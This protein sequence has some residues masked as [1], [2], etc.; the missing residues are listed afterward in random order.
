MEREGE[1][2]EVAVLIFLFFL[3]SLELKLNQVPATYS[4]PCFCGFFVFL[5]FGS[6]L[7]FTY[8]RA[9]TRLDVSLFLYVGVGVYIS[10]YIYTFTYI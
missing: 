4:F 7:Y 5:F 3:L 10:I 9:P 1:S 2:S 8:M 6:L